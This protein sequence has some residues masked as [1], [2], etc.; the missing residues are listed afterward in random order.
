MEY[1]FTVAQKWNEL[2]FFQIGEIAKLYMSDHKFKKEEFQLLL[3]AILFVDVAVGSEGYEEK[4]A[5]FN[6]LINE[7]HLI[8]LDENDQDYLFQ[9]IEFLESSMTLTKFPPTVE[10][11]G[12][13]YFGPA[14]RLSNITIEELTFADH[15]YFDWMTKK[16]QIDLDRLVTVLYRPESR[17]ENLE[18]RREDFSKQRLVERGSILPTMDESLKYAI[19]FAFKG[20]REAIFA[21]FKIVFPNVK[22]KF[23]GKE[24]KPIRY[25]SFNPMITSMAMGESSPLGNLHDVKK[26]NAVDFFEVVQE[27]III[28]RKRKEQLKS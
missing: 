4:A 24:R 5:T 25:K 28:D 11:E 14:N 10:L 20:S 1:D 13:V 6:V 3:L 2:N 22:S 16:R 7:V 8:K 27:T 9:Y 17:V 26:T 19:G 18:D 21:K 23:K 12:K 15:L